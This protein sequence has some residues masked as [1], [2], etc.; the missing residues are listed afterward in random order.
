MPDS[1]YREDSLPA[2]P[3]MPCALQ[4]HDTWFVSSSRS[5]S[6]SRSMSSLIQNWVKSGLE[7]GEGACQALAQKLKA[8]KTQD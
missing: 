5:R 6:K 8:L 3:A 7:S 1:L 4:S 2:L